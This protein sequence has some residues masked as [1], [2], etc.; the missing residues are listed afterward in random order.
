MS[1]QFFL[2]TRV[3]YLN[4]QMNFHDTA[5]L[6]RKVADLGKGPRGHALAILCGKNGSQYNGNDASESLLVY[7]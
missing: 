5:Q 2:H 3:K 1:M 4:Y 7:T 6:T